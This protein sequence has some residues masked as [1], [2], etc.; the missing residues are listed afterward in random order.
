MA[1]STNIELCGP[2]VS[3]NRATTGM[4]VASYQ[5]T[6]PT[7]GASTWIRTRKRKHLGHDDDSRAV[8]DDRG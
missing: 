2:S 5:P 4:P 7:A 1:G 3:I 8:G 6:E